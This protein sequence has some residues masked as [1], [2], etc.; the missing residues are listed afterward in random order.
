MQIIEGQALSKLC[1]YS[2][3]DHLAIWDE[4]LEG[5]FEP[6]HPSNFKFVAKCKKFEGKV[7]TLFIDNI[8][9]YNRNLDFLG[10]NA[11]T[12]ATFIQYLMAHNNLLALLKDFPNN[13]FIIFTSHEDTALDDQIEVPDNV[14]AIYAVNGYTNNP[15]VHPFPIGLQR[16]RNKNDGR[17]EYMRQRVFSDFLGHKNPNS[18]QPTKLLYINCGIERNPERVPLAHFHTSDWITTRFDKDSMFFPYDRYNV[19][20]DELQAHKFVVCPKGQQRG[21]LVC[22]DTHRLWETLYMRRV[23]VILDHPYFRKLLEGFPILYVNQWI[24]ITDKLLIA[25]DSLY[26]EVQTMDMNKLDLENLYKNAINQV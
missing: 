18:K 3:G 5:D 2:F 23:P 7:M 26:Q 11:L 21:N 6:A 12:D 22:Y 9:L 10:P 15:K 24:D 8:R 4:N 13:K 20:L 17:L 19:F 14:L 16:K 1:D 25:N